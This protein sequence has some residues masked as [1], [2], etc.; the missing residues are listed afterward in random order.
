MQREYWVYFTLAVDVKAGENL[1]EVW[2]EAT[3]ILRGGGG[4][5]IS[6][7]IVEAESGNTLESS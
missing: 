1:D 7:S 5:I 6:H 2:E 4:D 3:E